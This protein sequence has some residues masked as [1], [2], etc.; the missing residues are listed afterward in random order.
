MGPVG[1]GLL[2]VMPLSSVPH[3]SGDATTYTLTLLETKGWL[4]DPQNSLLNWPAP[5]QCDMIQVLSRL[6]AIRILGDFTTWYETVALD[7]VIMSNTQ[8][9][10]FLI[11]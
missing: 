1:K 4:K 2:I 5:T 8:S 9:K 10:Y 11:D 3:F 6:S 7:D